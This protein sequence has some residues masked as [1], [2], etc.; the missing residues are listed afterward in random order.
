MCFLFFFFFFC[1]LTVSYLQALYLGSTP[2]FLK[3]IFNIFHPVFL[4]VT[5]R[6]IGA[7]Q[8]RRLLSKQNPFSELSELNVH[9]LD[10]FS[11]IFSHCY[12]FYFDTYIPSKFLLILY[13]HS[14]LVKINSLDYWLPIVIIITQTF[15]NY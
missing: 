13:F 3:H 11:I 5:R 6:R 8:P 12:K 15:N 10:I 2:V 1:I 9:A 7:K 14:V 4:I